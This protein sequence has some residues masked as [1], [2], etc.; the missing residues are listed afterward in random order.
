VVSLLTSWVAQTSSSNVLQVAFT[1]YLQNDL[2]SVLENILPWTLLQMYSYYQQD[3][4][5]CCIWMSKSLTNGS[6]MVVC[7]VGHHGHWMSVCLTSMC[8]VTWKTCVTARWTWDELLKQIF[9]VVRCV[10]G[11]TVLSEVTLSIVEWVR[12]CIWA[13]SGHFEQLLDWTVQSFFP[14]HTVHCT[15]E[16]PPKK[17]MVSESSYI[18]NNHISI[19]VENQTHVH[20]TFLSGNGLRNKILKYW[21]KV[22]GQVV[23]TIHILSSV[24]RKFR[25]TSTQ[26][27]VRG[28]F[29]ILYT[30]LPLHR[31]SIVFSDIF[32]VHN[33]TIWKL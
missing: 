19:T 20:I 13:D 7:T 9:D 23:W 27:F 8:V 22:T 3:R 5:S 11:A 30:V 6:A 21:H 25:F 31:S 29:M 16:F 18:S 24:C 14:N 15:V 2:L 17:W 12:L 26:G 1:L 33:H 10:S 32:A 28:N 4:A